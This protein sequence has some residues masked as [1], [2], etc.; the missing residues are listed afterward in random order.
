MAKPI[1]LDEKTIKRLI[2]N[3]V[4]AAFSF[5]QPR[6]VAFDFKDFEYQ[7]EITRETFS[8][9]RVRVKTLTPLFTWLEISNHNVNYE[10]APND[11]INVLNNRK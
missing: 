10:Y 11:V 8:K 5:K 4:T 7:V 1:N 3:A 6:K 2:E 9:C